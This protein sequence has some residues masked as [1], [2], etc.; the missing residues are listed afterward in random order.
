MG[1]SKKTIA[2]LA[3]GS[4]ANHGNSA[5]GARLSREDWIS[6]ARRALIAGGVSRVKVLPLAESLGVTTGSFYWHF[7]DRP[8]LLKALIEHWEESNTRAF[9][10]VAK[11]DADPHEQFARIIDIWLREDDFDPTYD[12]AVRDWA[13]T[14]PD[15]EEAVHRVDDIRIEILHRIFVAMGDRE[16][17]ALVRARITYYHQVGYYAMRVRES[18]DVRRALRSVYVSLL[19]GRS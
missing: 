12:S 15:V 14:A 17:E 2:E 10:D 19:K 18:P 8:A 13:R 4:E 7:P 9:V 3:T 1:A 5:G 6:A 16:P 11:S